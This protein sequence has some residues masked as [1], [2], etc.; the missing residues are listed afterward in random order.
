[1]LYVS[2]D[3]L[4]ELM[5][6]EAFIRDSEYQKWDS[7]CWIRYKLFENCLKAAIIKSGLEIEKVGEQSTVWAQK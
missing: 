2:V 5:Y 6:D 7:G 3:I 1:M 4:K